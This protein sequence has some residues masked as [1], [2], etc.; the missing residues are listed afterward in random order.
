MIPVQIVSCIF[1]SFFFVVVAMLSNM[2]RC[3]AFIHSGFVLQ[4][5]NWASWVFK[6]K[7]GVQTEIK[8]ALNKLPQNAKTCTRCARMH[9]QD[10][11]MC[12][13]RALDHNN[14]AS[15]FKMHVIILTFSLLIR[16]ESAIFSLP[17][18]LL[19]S[20]SNGCFPVNSRCE[21]STWLC[22]KIYEGKRC[23]KDQIVAIL[24]HPPVQLVYF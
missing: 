6:F 14:G 24:D 13:K 16:E 8:L 1:M 23:G 20:L 19:P 18:R 2:S 3:S 9:A 12:T 5:P 10:M 11:Q 7:L 17:A 15:H 4:R 21:M 22:N